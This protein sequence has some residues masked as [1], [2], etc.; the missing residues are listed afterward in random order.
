VKKQRIGFAENV[1]KN[2]ANQLRFDKD[3]V[4]CQ[5]G[6]VFWNTLFLIN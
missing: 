3:I 4:K 6:V 1:V 2:F 5:V